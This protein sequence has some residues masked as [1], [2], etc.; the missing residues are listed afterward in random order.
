MSPLL[1][2]TFISVSWEFILSVIGIIILTWII[3][4]IDKHRR[5]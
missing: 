4:I 2:T 1:D 5:K 3:N